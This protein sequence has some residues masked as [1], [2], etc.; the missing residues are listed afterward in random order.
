MLS[1][2][3]ALIIVSVG[4]VAGFGLRELISRKRRAAAREEWLRRRDQ[5]RYDDGIAA[6]AP[7][8]VFSIS[9]EVL[10]AGTNVD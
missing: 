8:I 10:K 3:F 2:I 1:P 4:F 9:D 6:T 7:S 5:K